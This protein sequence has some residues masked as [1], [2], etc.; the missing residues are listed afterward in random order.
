MP[1]QR[2]LMFWAA[3]LLVLVLALWLLSAIL[4]PFIAGMVLAYILDPIAD[5]LERLGLPRL[6][7][8]LV[9]LGT[10]VVL[11]VI[12][13]LLLMPL[14]GDQIGKFIAYLPH[15]LGNLTRLFN[16]MA[17]QW[18]KDTLTDTGTNIPSS[19]SDLAGRAAV[20]MG[21]LLGSLWSGSLALFNLLSLLVVT[22][23][24]AFYML[25]DWDHMVAKVDSWLPR[26]HADTIRSLALQ[27]NETMA[28]FIRGQGTVCI[29][30]GVFYAV[31]LSVAG[32]SFGMLIG[33][34][35]G[36]LSFIPYVGTI[37]GAVVSIG[38]ALVQFW[39]DWVR[40]AVVVG[41]FVAG[42]FLEGNFLSPK[43]GG[44]RVGLH[45]VWLMFALFAFGYLFGFVGLLMAVPVAAALGVL[46]RFALKQYLSSP[47]YLGETP[48]AGR[49]SRI[50]E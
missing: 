21:S 9:I 45:P 47:L 35:A 7:A 19:V 4:L 32:L 26:Q 33:L 46:I 48:S 15:V 25:N 42:Q 5:A 50:K 2:Q 8:T 18:L 49:R 20:W 14:L 13:F 28:G 6:V 41:I 11:L 31:G 29:A 16:E 44:E 27:I 34:G 36:F 23:V 37:T 40:I 38:M 1:L 39:P 24:V 12:G 30:L 3:G 10:S 22:P 43:L 17:P